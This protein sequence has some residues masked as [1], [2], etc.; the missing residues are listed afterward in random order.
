MVGDAAAG[1]VSND[2]EREGGVGIAHPFAAARMEIAVGQEALCD[3]AYDDQVQVLPQRPAAGAGPDGAHIGK[4][5]QFFSQKAH[6]RG[7]GHAFGIH[8]GCKGGVGTADAFG[9]LVGK[10]GAEGREGLAAKG[11][12]RRLAAESETVSQQR[13]QVV[14]LAGE[15]RPDPV[16]GKQG[17]AVGPHSASSTQPW[18]SS[19]AA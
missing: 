5:I 12:Q 2:P 8:S 14:C 17:D 16:S 11:E 4:E 13:Q 18:R 6:R 1:A 9:R 19:T 10:R 15:D 7:A 3:L